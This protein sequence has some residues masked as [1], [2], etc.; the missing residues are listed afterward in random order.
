MDGFQ[1]VTESAPYV[2]YSNRYGTKDPGTWGILMRGSSEH[3][4]SADLSKSAEK[5]D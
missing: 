1:T 3:R 4:M 5:H 2:H